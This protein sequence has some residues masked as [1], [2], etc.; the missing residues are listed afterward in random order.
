MFITK[1]NMIFK[2][3]ALAVVFLFL[4]H[5]IAWAGDLSNYSIDDALTKQYKEQSSMFAPDYI[6]RQQNIHEEIISQKQAAENYVYTYN[7][8]SAL[9]E[10]SQEDTWELQGP[11]AVAMSTPPNP[12]SPHGLEYDRIEAGSDGWTYYYLGDQCQEYAHEDGRAYVYT[13]REN[14]SRDQIVYYNADNTVD[15]VTTYLY[16]E[17]G[18]RTGSIKE[19]TNG[20]VYH[21]DAQGLYRKVVF[22]NGY[23]FTYRE[24]YAGTNKVKIREYYKP[25]GIL[26]YTDTFQYDADWKYSG[27]IREYPNGTIRE[28]DKDNKLIRYVICDD[29]GSHLYTYYYFYDSDGNR[30]GKKLEYPNGTAKIYDKDNNLIEY[31]ICGAEGALLYTYYYFFDSNG[32]RT[33]K[34]LVYPSGKTYEYDENNR[35]IKLTNSNG[36]YAL[37]TE[38]YPNNEV[39][40]I[41]YYTPE[42]EWRFTYTYHRDAG[43]NYRGKTVEYPGGKVYEYDEENKLIK[44]TYGN[45]NYITYTYRED[46]KLD[47]FVYQKPDGALLYT[48][49]YFYDDDGER[50]G[51]LI[52]YPNGTKYYYDSRGRKTKIVSANGNYALYEYFFETSRLKTITHYMADDTWRYTVD[53]RYDPDENYTGYAIEYPDGTIKEYDTENRLVRRAYA[54]GNYAIYE[55][56]SGTDRLKTITHY[57]ADDTWRYTVTYLYDPDEKYTGYAVE[58]PNGEIKHYDIDGRMVRRAYANGYYDKYEYYSNCKYKIKTRYRADDSLRVIVGYLYDTKWNYTGYTYTY[59]S[60]YLY[61]YDTDNKLIKKT[62]PNYTYLEYFYDADGSLAVFIKYMPGGGITIYDKDGNSTHECAIVRSISGIRVV[63]NS[64]GEMITLKRGDRGRY[65]LNTLLDSRGALT[66]WNY[67]ESGKMTDYGKMLSDGTIEKYDLEGRIL[68]KRIPEDDFIKGVNLPWI[69]YGYDL[70]LRPGSTDHIGFSSYSTSVSLYEK[71]EAWKGSTARVFLF[72]DLRSSVNFDSSGTPIS[73]TDKVY[74]D[75]RFLLEAA[76]VFSVKLIPTL[77]DYTI[78]DRVTRENFYEV[79]ERPDLIADPAKRQALL[80]LFSAFLDEF[81]GDP[82]IYAWDVINEPEYA[83][84]VSVAEMKSFVADFADLIH[85]K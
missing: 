35:L 51:W 12:A 85:A 79:G 58:Y 34:K 83:H 20:T 11:K 5:Q 42:G 14:G 24:Y 6:V 57:M 54:N 9:T 61:V 23:Y 21:Y 77:F 17:S 46:G 10:S 31:R 39:K 49:T 3:I 47:Y 64:A 41:E 8:K 28:Y 36:N 38:Y 76:K 66:Y 7:V 15:F 70:G 37:Y 59:P 80:D 22:A 16:D 48:Q 69:R 40:I 19:H 44:L 50:T 53:Y 72:C 4:W 75:M 78:A 56:F 26:Y 32:N 30:T 1:P 43:G 45:A 62:E 81:A 84:A 71:L 74:E 60:G 27:K 73:F 68:E 29:A 67:D 63:E 55:Y 33:G 2:S 13:Y 65:F 25:G 52:E 82:S 18:T